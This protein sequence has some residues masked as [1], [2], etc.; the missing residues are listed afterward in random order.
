MIME[1]KMISRTGITCW[2]A[3]CVNWIGSTFTHTGFHHTDSAAW[4]AGKSSV[5]LPHPVSRLS[6]SRWLADG[7]SCNG[8]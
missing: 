7:P 4:H 8:M 3:H 6:G 1:D 5:L 2:R